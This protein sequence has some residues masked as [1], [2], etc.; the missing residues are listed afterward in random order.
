MKKNIRKFISLLLCFCMLLPLVSCGTNEPDGNLLVFGNAN[1]KDALRICIDVSASNDQELKLALGDFWI[2]LQQSGGL[3]GVIFEIVPDSNVNDIAA[4]NTAISR[5]RTEI[6]AGTGPDV[7]ILQGMYGNEF[8]EM[9]IPYPQKSMELGMFLPLDEYMENST[10]FTEWDKQEQAILA[11]GRNKEG[12]QII[13]LSYTLPLQVC[14]QADLQ[15]DKPDTLLTWDDTMH[16]PDW[17]EIY[18]GFNDCSRLERRTQMDGTVETVRSIEYYFAYV[19]GAIA[20]FEQEELLFTEEELL[21]RVTEV[22]KLHDEDIQPGI[23]SEYMLSR[24]ISNAAPVTMLPLY[25]SDGGV[26]AE[27]NSFAAV[28]CN[29]KYPD[30]AFTVID[31]LLRENTQ[32]NSSLFRNILCGGPGVTA[33]PL[34]SDAYN[35]DQAFGSGF[36]LAEE[37]CREL[38][39]IKEQIT[40]VNFKGDLTTD[41]NV[42]PIQCRDSDVSGK[43]IEELV[44]ETYELMQ[45]KVRE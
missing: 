22:L 31:L 9:L 21:E 17:A 7:F 30:E 23:F 5:L 1:A 18:K 32:L 26:T 42:L 27:V 16:D 35:P 13:P 4:R 39:D 36:H 33:A 19:I 15:V 34:L 24:Q 40:A 38:T 10:E 12:Q 6:M 28:N 25:S 14:P 43:S 11:A 29:T 2:S 41:L 44:H 45:R 20:D 37:S 8:T 3:E